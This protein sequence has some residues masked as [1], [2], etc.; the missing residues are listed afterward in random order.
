MQASS[1]DAIVPPWWQALSDRL[2]ELVLVADTQGHIVYVNQAFQRAFGYTQAELLGQ[3]PDAFVATHQN[4]NVF[5]EALKK[6]SGGHG[7]EYKLS[8]HTKRGDTLDVS[9]LITAFGSEGEKPTHYVCIGRDLS[10]ERFLQKQLY[11]MQRMEAMGSLAR[12]IA[13]RFNNVL[14]AISGQT[15]LLKARGGLDAF[16]EERTER[17]LN[18]VENGRDLVAQIK[19]FVR[20]Q[21]IHHIPVDFAGVVRQNVRFIE[22]V[23]PSGVQIKSQLTEESCEV[24]AVP[25]ELHQVVLNLLNNGLEA[26][27][28]DS[29]GRIDV[30]LSHIEDVLAIPHTTPLPRPQP[31]VRLKITDNGPGISPADELHLFEPFFTTRQERGA[32]GMGLT[33]VRAVLERYRGKIRLYSAPEQG[34]TVEVILPLYL[35]EKQA[36][37]NL[38]GPAGNGE[39]ILLLDDEPYIC[40]SGTKL[41][42]SLGYQVTALTDPETLEAVLREKAFAL[43]VMD[44]GLPG[45]N[46]LERAKALR[47]KG[48]RTPVVLTTPLELM[49]E[50]WEISAAGVQRVLPK[51][52]PA[53][54]L[55]EAVYQMLARGGA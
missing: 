24:M 2:E 4:R 53:R 26:F 17:I 36:D 55:T 34:T 3:R 16:A 44:M 49:P 20:K 8:V 41:F 7:L 1:P 35:S 51:P 30:K 21:G 19:G 10:R 15:E 32:L 39:A 54:E 48:V 9:V 45:R 38:L 13:H 11:E 31:C 12:G 14:G 37:Q 6:V 22:Q 42:E 29:G 40:E 50:P 5:A 27:D 52:C 28:G 25:E 18:A 23:A 43:I 33:V 46:G 47:A